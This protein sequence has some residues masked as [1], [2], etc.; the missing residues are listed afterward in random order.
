VRHSL[1]RDTID[2]DSKDGSVGSRFNRLLDV[3]LSARDD[4][5]A[6]VVSAFLSHVVFWKD[7]NVVLLR[8]GW[9]GERRSRRLDGG[10]RCAASSSFV[11][12]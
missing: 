8:L 9:L 3:L 5:G 7:R 11:C 1:E 12:D 6:L 4:H 2:V 10:I